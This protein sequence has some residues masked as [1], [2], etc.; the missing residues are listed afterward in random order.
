MRLPGASKLIFTFIMAL[1]TASM[2]F[3]L[4]WMVSASFKYEVD[5]FNYPLQWIPPKWNAI[6]N[7]SKVWSSQYSFPLYYWNT[8]KVSVT[9]TVLQ[10]L[11]ASMGA[12]AFAKLRF[13]FKD[14]LFALFIATMMIPDQVTIVPKFMLLT[15]LNLIDSHAGLVL[16]VVF[17]VYGIFL[18]RQYMMSLP[19]SLVEAAKIDGAGYSRIYLQIVLP[20]SQPVLATLAIL[21]FI[22]TWDDYQNP[23]IFL[24]SKEL[25]TIQLG[26]SQFA[27]QSGTFYSL[28]MAAAVC[29]IVPLLL[30]FIVGQRFIIDGMTS[31]AVKG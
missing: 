30:L 27:S 18:L 6:A 8:L 25:F 24:R 26:M 1:L 4:L 2:L 10:L 5:V 13:K 3:P 14:G 15:W 22:W 28:L 31:G 7:Y 17:S 29:A 16:I 12:F 21:R 11:I 19:D 9:V 20:I 23:L